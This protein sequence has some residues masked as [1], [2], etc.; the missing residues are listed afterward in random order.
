MKVA[1]KKLIKINYGS[2]C[3]IKQENYKAKSFT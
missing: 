3:K 1:D 2:H